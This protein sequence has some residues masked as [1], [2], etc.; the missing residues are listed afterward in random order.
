MSSDDLRQMDDRGLLLRRQD[1]MGELTS[2]KFRHATGSLKDTSTLRQ[3]RH[4]LARVNT[5]IRQREQAEGLPKGGLQQRVGKLDPQEN[6]FAAFR[7]AMAAG[8]EG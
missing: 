1:V 7:K 5:L 6:V 3:L 2:S 8:L 4:E